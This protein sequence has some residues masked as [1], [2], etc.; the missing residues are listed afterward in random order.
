[1]YVRR[2]KHS[3]GKVYVQV[4]DKS[5][6]KYKVV[7]S[8]G[9][10]VEQSSVDALER[11][12]DIWI[13]SQRGIVEFDFQDETSLITKV[14]NNII[15]HK[16]I[17]IELVLGKIFDSIGFNQIDDELFRDLVLYRLVYPKSK[18]KTTEYLYRYSQKEYSE[19]EIYRYLDKLYD[20]QKE[21]V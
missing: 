8:F 1:M 14:L 21:I 2:L 13:K 12:A 5:S 9:S 18:L 10:A 4:I 20:S 3:N 6:G 16:L 19:D 11:K 17:G 7:K 15:S